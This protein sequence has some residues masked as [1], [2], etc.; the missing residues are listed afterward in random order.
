MKAHLLHEAQDFDFEAG[1]PPGHEA[2]IQDLEL[3]TL[4][5]AMASGDKFLAEVSSKVLLASLHDPPAIRYRQQVLADCLA[6]PEVIREMYAVAV[7]ALEDQRR[8]WWGGYGGTYQSPSSNLSG[9]VSHLEGYVARLSQLRKIADDHAGKFRSQGMK[10]LFATL[11]SELDDAYFEEISYHLKQLRF[12]AGV[13]ISAEL[14]RDNSGINFLLR[15]GGD[16]RR[17]WR[18]RLGIGPR[19]SYSFTLPPRDEAGGKILEDLTGRGVNLVANAAAQSADHIGSYFTMLRAELGF[20]VSCLNL[21]DRLAAKDVTTTVPE[22]AQ[23]SS[24]T[25]SCTGLRDTCLELQS[26]SPV[27][28]NDVHADGKSLVII[29]GAN[30]GGKSTF[31]RSVGLAQLMMQC[32]LFVTAQSYQ[33][34]AAPGIFTHFIREED[35]SMTSGRLD[36][37]L[38][39]MSAIADQIR[40]YCLMLF[41]E[42]FAGTNEREGSEI[43]HQ[44]V[45]ALLDAQVKVFFVTHRFD[46]AERFRRERAPSTLFLRAERRPDGSRNYKLAVKDPLPTSFGEDLY[47]RLGG[48]LDEDKALAPAAAAIP[49]DGEADRSSQVRHAKEIAARPP[50]EPG[51]G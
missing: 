21:A 25:F 12:R 33:A 1:L 14:D 26:G 27:V 19:S 44:V 2:V 37:E 34:N 17:P 4:L 13:L 30:S 36:D 16:A 51:T 8:R 15:A 11:Q 48:W 6:E 46:F 45:R 43:G 39:R 47:Y 10:T 29:T 42:S 41:N 28:G 40:P 24:L 7:G 20:Y 35:P 9:A 5:Q 3:T 50:D 38:R 22:P 31:L 23:P 18:E 32:G 49:P